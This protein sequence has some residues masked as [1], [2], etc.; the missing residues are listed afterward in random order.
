M[1]KL[2]TAIAATCLLV[3]GIAIAQMNIGDNLGTNEADIRS[4]LEAQGYAISEIEIEDNEIEVE[5][6]RDGQAYEIEVS[7]ETGLVIE[8]A[9]DD[10]DDESDDD[11]DGSDKS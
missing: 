2:T 5:A 4:A 7:V 11:K 1:K 10:E 6:M 9:L 3:P 8:V